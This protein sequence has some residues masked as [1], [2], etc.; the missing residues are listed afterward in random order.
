M[1]THQIEGYSTKCLTWT[2][3]KCQ[4]HESQGETENYHK[5]EETKETRQLNAM[6]LS[7]MGSWNSKKAL[8]ENLVK[9]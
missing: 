7:W 5:L 3:Q 4:G 9:F 8:V 1:K 2:L 6:W